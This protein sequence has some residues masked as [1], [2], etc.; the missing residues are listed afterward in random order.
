MLDGCNV[1]EDLASRLW[2]RR[3]EQAQRTKDKGRQIHAQGQGDAS[4]QNCPQW[5]QLRW[6]LVTVV[7]AEAMTVLQ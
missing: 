3:A 7:P 5:D 2:T 6:L 1:E 4:Q